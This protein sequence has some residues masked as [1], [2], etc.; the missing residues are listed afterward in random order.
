ME[1]KEAKGV[2]E[3]PTDVAEHR[4]R[5]YPAKI[6]NQPSEMSSNLISA[7]FHS[8]WQL[9]SA[10]DRVPEYMKQ[11]EKSSAQPP[12]PQPRFLPIL[13]VVFTLTSF[14][15]RLKKKRKRAMNIPWTSCIN[16]TKRGCLH[17]SSSF[18]AYFALFKVTYA[19]LMPIITYNHLSSTTAKLIIWRP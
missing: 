19:P 9:S 7:N 4:P 14:P 5:C 12:P 2:V 18:I 1:G 17:T 3:F 8:A 6:I 10:G 16:F 15:W 13:F 11:D